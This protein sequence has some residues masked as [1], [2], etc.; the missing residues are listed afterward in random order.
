MKS[1]G[2]L[3]K[4]LLRYR[5]TPPKRL[6][7]ASSSLEPLEGL[8]EVGDNIVSVFDTDREPHEV[9]PDP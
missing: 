8:F 2:N 5:I 3:M 4:M 7:D 1:A 6:T 9:L